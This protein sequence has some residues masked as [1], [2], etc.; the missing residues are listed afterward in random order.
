MDYPDNTHSVPHS[1]KHQKKVTLKYSFLSY[2]FIWRE[3]IQ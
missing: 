3:M 1:S 2:Y